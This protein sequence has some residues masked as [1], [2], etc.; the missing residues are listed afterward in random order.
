MGRVHAVRARR[1]ISRSC[2]S[3]G[4]ARWIRCWPTRPCPYNSRALIDACRPFEK[5]DTFPRVAQSSPARVREAVAKW[6]DLFADPRFPLPETVIP[7]GAVDEKAR[8]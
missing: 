5:L 4:A 8:G 6:K 7:S 2:G 1:T 3:R